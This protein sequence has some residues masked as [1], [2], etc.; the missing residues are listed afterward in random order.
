MMM[1]IY[2]I[3]LA[4]LLWSGVRSPL[5]EKSNRDFK[6]MITTALANGQRRI[7]VAPGTWYMDLQDAAPLALH[8]LSDVE[9]IGNGANIICNTP[10]QAI[11]IRHC[12][13]LRISGLTIDYNPLPFTQGKIVA[14]DTLQR[15]W[16]EV[17]IYD[18]YRTD[19]IE[20]HLPDRFQIFDG[21]THTLRKNLYTYFSGAF[22]KV[23]KT[24]DHLFRFYK[25]GYNKD[26]CEVVGDEVVFSLPYP[27]KT[28]PH[29]IIISQSA[30]VHLEDITLFAGNCFGFFELECNHNV[31]N[32][33][34]VT[35]KINDSLVSYPRLRSN[36]ADAF[37]SKFAIHGPEITHCEFQYQGDDG[38]A[39]NTSFYR[40]TRCENNKVYVAAT[41]LKIKAGHRVRFVSAGGK[42]MED[43]TV[44]EMQPADSGNATMLTLDKTVSAVAGDL[45]SSLDMAGAGFIIKHNSIGYT[46]ARGILVKSSEGVIEDNTVTGCELGGI[47]L[48]PEMNWM[49]AGFSRNVLIKHNLI[50]DCMFAN[51]SY[52][53]E[54]AAPISVVAVNMHHK[55]APAGG[56]SNIRIIGNTIENS[57]LPAIM[58]TS[59][60]GGEVTNNHIGI[61]KEIVRSHGS[62]FGVDNSQ[63]VWQMNTQQVLIRKNKIVHP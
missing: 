26:A 43:A 61:S 63:P 25:S 36:N 8:D 23:E 34:R 56:F 22:S 14:M 15:L 48:A 31:Y 9:I 28:R 46:R 3:A 62:G 58:I 4:V 1:K 37:H 20:D 7:V 6:T 17:R 35:K 33:C 52:G 44:L 39:V 10:T 45:F 27:G 19:M 16:V 38:I 57:P 42:V 59:V 41:G 21:H 47:V 50:K 40:V 32:R 24:G 5:P 54:Q 60:N 53:I 49:E 12:N 13:N 11:D 55:I 29:A 30:N 18:G 51:S 2:L